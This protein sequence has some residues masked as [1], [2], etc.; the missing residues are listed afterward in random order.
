VSIT[1]TVQ[2]LRPWPNTLFTFSLHYLVELLSANILNFT[3]IS[4]PLE[5]SIDNCLS[6][7]VVIE[8]SDNLPTD[9]TIN[10]FS[11]PDLTEL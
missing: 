10:R 9:T 5:Y 4:Q 3:S 7:H 11:T 6:T 8:Y 2:T 1:F